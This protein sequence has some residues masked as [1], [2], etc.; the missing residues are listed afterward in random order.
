MPRKVGTNCIVIVLAVLLL[1]LAAA[2]A[3]TV[4]NAYCETSESCN[5]SVVALTSDDGVIRPKGCT[6]E[7]EGCAGRCFRCTEGSGS[8]YCKR[9]CGATCEAEWETN[10]CGYA[11]YFDC[12]GTW[13]SACECTRTNPERNY[14]ISCQ[15]N[16]CH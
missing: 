13:A 6:Q 7:G 3:T 2:W 8:N 9:K 15:L 16:I 4:Q 10:L 5:D 11:T 12:A 14:N 1:T